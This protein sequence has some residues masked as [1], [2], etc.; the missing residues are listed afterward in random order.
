[1]FLA[2]KW[3]ILIKKESESLIFTGLKIP[4]DY[5]GKKEDELI[6][7]LKGLKA[8][9]GS[10]YQDMIAVLDHAVD[11]V[12]KSGIFSEIGKSGSG[13]SGGSQAEERIESIAKGLSLIHI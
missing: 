5:I 2:K 8:A 11:A 1:M 10:A 9:G 12:E 7:M 4:R 6:P 3:G 13:F